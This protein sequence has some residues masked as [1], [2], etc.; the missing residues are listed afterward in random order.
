MAV[1]SANLFDMGTRQKLGDRTYKVEGA[2]TGLSD[3]A[4]VAVEARLREM[5]ASG[6]APITHG[7]IRLEIITE[8]VGS[9]YGA[10]LLAMRKFARL[11]EVAPSSASLFLTATEIN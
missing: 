10:L 11:F 5:G 8:Q 7:S 4:A 3:F 9:G 6:G 1:S 2:I